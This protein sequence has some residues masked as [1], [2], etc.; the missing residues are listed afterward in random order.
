MFIFDKLCRNWT[1]HQQITN[2]KKYATGV[3]NSVWIQSCSAMHKYR[4]S[5]IFFFGGL[6]MC[7]HFYS[8]YRLHIF[9]KAIIVHNNYISVKTL[10]GKS[11]VQKVNSKKQKK[12]PNL[13]WSKQHEIGHNSNC[14]A[15]ICFE[16]PLN[17]H[18]QT[19]Y[20]KGEK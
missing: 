18:K 1:L 19:I 16:W 4:N 10:N 11:S 5:P 17:M 3:Y 13:L 12:N 8:V 2:E 9:K 20:S 6:K 14:G 7:L 15:F